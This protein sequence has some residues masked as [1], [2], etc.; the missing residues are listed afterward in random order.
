MARLQGMTPQ[1][2]GKLALDTTKTLSRERDLTVSSSLQWG[3]GG[4]G[5]VGVGG[6]F[7][8]LARKA[9]QQIGV[10][11]RIANQNDKI[12]SFAGG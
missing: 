9:D 4:A 10:L 2:L 3:G 11:N 5:Q 7:D 12:L 6:V 1:D 8:K